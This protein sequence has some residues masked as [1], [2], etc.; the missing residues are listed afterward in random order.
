[1]WNGA[2]S[3]FCDPGGDITLSFKYLFFRHLIILFFIWV[4]KWVLFF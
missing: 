3:L 4:L 1:M 2:F